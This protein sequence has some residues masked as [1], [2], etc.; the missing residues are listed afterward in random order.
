MAHEV[1]HSDEL[2][3][4]VGVFVQARRVEAKGHVIYVSGLTARGMDNDI[5]GKGDIRVQTRQVM[6][7]MKKVL[8][9]GG[10]TFD[11]VVK[12]TV[13]IR[14]MNH[15]K[16]IHEV[17]AQYFVNTRPASTMVEVSRMVHPDC[18]IEIEAIACV[19]D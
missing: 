9:E 4:P 2:G 6:E 11:D 18:L 1:L 3:P 15:F 10:A 8:A 13:F 17:R 12:V 5:V 19:Q 7:N 16:E 14:D